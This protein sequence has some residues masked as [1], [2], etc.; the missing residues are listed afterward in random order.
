MKLNGF[1]TKHKALTPETVLFVL[2]T[3]TSLQQQ[4][5]ED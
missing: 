4:H 2:V 5:P 3:F 1:E